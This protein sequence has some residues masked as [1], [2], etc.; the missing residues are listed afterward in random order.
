MSKNAV[1]KQR[2]ITGIVFGMI[3]VALIT[4]SAYGAI[5]LALTI[6]SLGSFELIKMIY[7]NSVY[8][9]LFGV[10]LNLLII[11]S[12][13][14]F[15]PNESLYLFWTA[16]SCI[17]MI[18][19]VINLYFNI[20]NFKSNWWLVSLL[21]LG[22]PLGLFISFLYN[23]KP[24]LPY[25]WLSVIVMIWMSDSF[26][27]LIGSRIGKRKLFE[28]ISPKKSWEGFLGAGMVALPIAYWIGITYFYTADDMYGIKP[29]AV[30]NAGIFWMLLAAFVWVVGTMGDLVESSIKRA[31][32]IKDSGKILPG[33]GGIL[34]RFDSF[35][36]I[37]PFV[38]L[39]LSFYLQQSNI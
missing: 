29:E 30:G 1:L 18:L 23:V 36:Y 21:Y 4:S 15:H 27:Y 14:Q 39:L 34:D 7:P 5:F 17:I 32:N 12:L 24:Y 10:L 11:I 25:F 28:K 20:I 19:G 37:L 9:W 22:L 35:I 13:T 6:A 33:H 38:L 16:F 2:T 3:V 26:A 31:F 8:K